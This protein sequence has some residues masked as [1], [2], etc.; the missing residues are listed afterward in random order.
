MPS[1]KVGRSG[2]R[3]AIHNWRVKAGKKEVYSREKKIDCEQFIRDNNGR[4]NGKKLRLIPPN[5]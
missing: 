4:L 5:D 1:D 2:R 3:N